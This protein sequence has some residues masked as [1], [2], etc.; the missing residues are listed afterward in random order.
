LLWL[1]YVRLWLVIVAALLGVAPALAAPATRS[2]SAERLARRAVTARVR[3]NGRRRLA[4]ARAAKRLLDRKPVA[5]KAAPS[6]STLPKLPPAPPL[7][8]AL[9]AEHTR[10]RSPR[11]DLLRL[12]RLAVELS[13]GPSTE[14]FKAAELRTYLADYKRNWAAGWLNER[15]GQYRGSRAVG[16][17][18]RSKVVFDKI[19]SRRQQQMNRRLSKAW[20]IVRGLV[21][22]EILERIPPVEIVVTESYAVPGILEYPDG[23]K[24]INLLPTSSVRD[25]LHELGHLIEDYG[26]PELLARVHSIRVQRARGNLIGLDQLLPGSSYRPQDKALAGAFIE[27]YMGRHYHGRGFTEILSM[28]LERFHSKQSALTFFN[29]DGDYMLELVGALQPRR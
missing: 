16:W 28:G 21:A 8:A 19:G 5:K 7:I 26:T 2:P 12:E 13:K 25:I 10:G 24:A 17:T 1:G 18:L 3:E 9:V 6:L 22:P 29:Q 23:R 20:S 27:T 14:L 11:A 15:L 4:P